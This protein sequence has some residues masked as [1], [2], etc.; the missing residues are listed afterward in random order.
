[1]RTFNISEIYVDED[2]PKTV[3]LAAAAFIIISTTNRF[4]G[5]SM[6]QLVFGRD[7]ILPIKC[8]VDW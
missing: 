3:I 5:Y 4:K 2:N 1:M 7:I 8:N 6:G